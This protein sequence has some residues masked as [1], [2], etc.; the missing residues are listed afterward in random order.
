MNRNRHEPHEEGIEI[1][2]DRIDPDTL[3]RMVEEFVTREGEEAGDSAYTLEEKV[4]QVLRQL[5]THTARVVFD[6]T[7]GSWNIVT[8]T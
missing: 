2:L 7:T 1:P 3:R 5:R 6:A 8:A 4:G